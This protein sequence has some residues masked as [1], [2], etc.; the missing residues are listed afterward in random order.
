MK[1][2]FEK[3]MNLRVFKEPLLKIQDEYVRLDNMIKLIYDK[4]IEKHKESNFIFLN[5]VSK[6]D[7]LTPLKT[8]TRGYSIV[9]KKDEIIKSKENLKQGDEIIIRLVD[10]QVDAYIK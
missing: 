9:Q 10:G 1:L 4:A 5:L 7:S 6:L 3:V 2:R 8:L